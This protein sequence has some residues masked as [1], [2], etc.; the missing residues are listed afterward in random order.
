M[1]LTEKQS[2]ILKLLFTFLSIMLSFVIVELLARTF[3][4][5]PENLQKL[6]ASNV[7][8]H[9]N[10]PNS[11]YRH[12]SEESG[13]LQ[14]TFNSFG[15]RDAEFKTEKDPNTIRIAVLGDSFEEAI[16]VK[17]TDRWP[18][19][20]SENLST[21]LGR[22]VESYNFGISGYG[23][24]QEWLELKNKIWQFHPN[25]VILAFSQNDLGD[26]Y[27]NKL[28]IVKNGQPFPN[29]PENQISGNSLG[30]FVRKMYLYQYLG[31]VLSKNP[32]SATVFEKIRTKVFGF[33]E[34]KRYLLSDAQLTN[35]PFEV[36]ASQPNQ[37]DE[38]KS[39]W[40]IIEAILKDMK[41]NTEE[42]NAKFLITT[43]ITAPEVSPT[44]WEK[45]VNQYHIDPTSKA[46]QISLNLL[47]ICADLKI[48]CSDPLPAVQDYVNNVGNI[49]SPLDPHYNMEGHNLI[50]TQLTNYILENKILNPGN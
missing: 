39:S 19:I 37:T 50:A 17:P 48:D 30:K 14:I 20:L 35:G 2:L 43:N 28:V 18:T 38:V 1:T 3:L 9:E 47:K 7:Y 5:K 26:V 10:I 21:A 27:K 8:I 36:I 31:S 16:Q 41:K 4:P 45:L 29:P 44:D 22:P 6:E 13:L 33:S 11:S 40:Q 49:H 23:T 46:N 15:Y 12:I 32:I 24:D 42:H 25:L 34:D